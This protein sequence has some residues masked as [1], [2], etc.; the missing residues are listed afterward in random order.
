MA[1]RATTTSRACGA[2]VPKQEAGR[3]GA[4]ELVLSRANKSVRLFGHVVDCLAHGWQ[5]PMEDI[6][7]VGYL[8]RTTAVYG[9][10]KFGLS[11][12][13]NT[14]AGGLFRRPFEAEMLTS[15]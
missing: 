7:R 14:F 6:V 2:N 11:D 1:I 8:M 10:G 5:P 13:V 4:G 15:T 3:C 9:N 12:L